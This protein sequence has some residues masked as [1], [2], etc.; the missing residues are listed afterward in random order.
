MV[1]KLPP[2]ASG[3]QISNLRNAP[4]GTGTDTLLTNLAYILSAALLAPKYRPTVLS[5]L[6][7]SFLLRIEVP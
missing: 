5:V 7:F 4:S 1:L 3:E 6:S 2:S